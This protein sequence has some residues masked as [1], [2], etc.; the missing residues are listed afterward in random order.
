MYLYIAFITDEKTDTAYGFI[1]LLQTDSIGFR[2]SK[3]IYNNIS[4]VFNTCVNGPSGNRAYFWVFGI[5]V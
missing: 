3:D 4:A 2:D 1:I 5:F